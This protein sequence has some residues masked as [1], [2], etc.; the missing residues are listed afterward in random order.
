MVLAFKIEREKERE[1]EGRG[2][3]E[4]DLSLCLRLGKDKCIYWK[5]NS[6][7]FYTKTIQKFIIRA[8]FFPKTQINKKN[9]QPLWH[10]ISS[11][12]SRLHN[13]HLKPIYH[14][15]DQTITSPFLDKMIYFL[16]KSKNS[17]SSFSF[18]RI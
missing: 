14:N 8:P 15:K 5:K 11:L 9:P 4:N 3:E 2:G 6:F 16:K 12:N 7:K 13:P 10:I 17:F 18:S 1:S